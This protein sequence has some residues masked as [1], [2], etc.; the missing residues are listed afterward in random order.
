MI[1]L[2]K[3]KAP[4]KWT[5]TFPD[6]KKVSF[7]AHG[8][9]DYTIHHDRERMLRY[10]ARH[11]KNENWSNPRTAGFWARHLLWSKPTMAEA[12]KETERQL[13]QKIKFIS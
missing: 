10:L 11:K 5:A 8:Y 4:K 3:A 13:G 12:I 7:G 2:T 6:G 1:V 9:E